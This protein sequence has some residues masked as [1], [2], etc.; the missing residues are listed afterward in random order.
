M[1]SN[2]CIMHNGVGAQVLLRCCMLC[3]EGRC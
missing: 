1:D 3:D 2:A